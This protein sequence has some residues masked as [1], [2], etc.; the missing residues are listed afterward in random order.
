[1]TIT[2]APDIEEAVLEEARREGTTPESIVLD[3]VREKLGSRSAATTLAFEPQDDWERRL[4][5]VGTDCGVSLPD[6]AL[7][8]EGLY[9]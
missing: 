6:E 3:A 5:A 1:V 8:R 9:D 2:L 4:L 7:S